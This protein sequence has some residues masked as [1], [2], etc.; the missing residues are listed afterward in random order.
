MDI[1]PVRNPSPAYEAHRKGPEIKSATTPE[2]QEPPKD[3]VDIS[4]EA[5]RKLAEL[6][7]KAR[8]DETLAQGENP[9]QTAAQQSGNHSGLDRAVSID[10]IKQRIDAGYYNRAEVISKI[11]DRL[12]DEF[13][14]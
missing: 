11:A 3:R 4:L 1:G 8:A 6:A 9:E 7:E 2:R 12:S 10:E 5:R 14:S 13:E